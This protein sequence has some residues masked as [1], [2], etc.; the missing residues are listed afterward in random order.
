MKNT[1]FSRGVFHEKRTAL[2]LEFGGFDYSGESGWFVDG[3]F[4]QDFAVE[5]DFSS[6]EVGDEPAVGG[7]VFT[8]SRVNTR[9]PQGTEGA[10][11]VTAVA[12]GEL[13]AAGSGLLGPFD[14]DAVWA[15]KALGGFADFVVFGAGGDAS[16]NTHARPPT[17]CEL[18]WYWSRSRSPNQPA[19]ACE[20]R[21]SS[22]E[23]G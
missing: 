16:F 21:F 5:V 3:Q 12:V 10:L 14:A 19:C 11:A 15:A 2:L 1:P 8:G 22:A 6:L 9:V 20:R 7:A 17:S 13:Q 18:C 23:S 4:G